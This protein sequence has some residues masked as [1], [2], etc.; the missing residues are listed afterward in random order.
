MLPELLPL[1][2]NR[3]FRLYQLTTASCPVLERRARLFPAVPYRGAEPWMLLCFRSCCKI[4]R[5]KWLLGEELQIPGR[6][7][8]RSSCPP[9]TGRWEVTRGQ[10]QG[11]P[12]GDKREHPP[13]VTTQS[14]PSCILTAGYVPRGEEHATFLQ[15]CHPWA[16]RGHW[17]EPRC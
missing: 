5:R 8:E 3:C 12:G 13:W 2:G 1:Q 16:S 4:Q 6:L 15:I 7:S 17:E 10:D 11:I 14:P 9:S